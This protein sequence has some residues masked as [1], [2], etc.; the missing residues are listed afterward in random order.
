MAKLI[1][2]GDRRTEAK[3]KE[4]EEDNAAATRRAANAA[5][6]RSDAVAVRTRV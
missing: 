6:E 1:Q 3:E 4:E 2:C 5:R